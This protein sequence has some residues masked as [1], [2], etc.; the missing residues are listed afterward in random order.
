MNFIFL[1]IFA[2][3]FTIIYR[4]LLIKRRQNFHYI[5]VKLLVIF[6][7]GCKNFPRN[8][9]PRNSRLYVDYHL[10]SIIVYISFCEFL[11][12]I[13][14]RSGFD[15]RHWFFFHHIFF[16]NFIIFPSAVEMSTFI[17]IFFF[18]FEEKFSVSGIRKI[19]FEITKY[20]ISLQKNI[21]MVLKFCMEVDNSTADGKLIKV[22]KK[23]WRKQSPCWGS[24]PDLFG[25]NGKIQIS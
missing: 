12:R 24:N 18:F 22:I 11:W 10:A 4:K 5:I 17:Q 7:Y 14:K 20:W 6:F 9:S 21:F 25:P 16:I 13:L 23:V 2:L 1:A 15:S 8:F 3:I 19:R